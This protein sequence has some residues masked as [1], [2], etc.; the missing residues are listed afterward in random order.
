MKQEFI[1]TSGENYRNIGILPS[2]TCVSEMMAD[3]IRHRME[4]AGLRKVRTS[5]RQGYIKRSSGKCV[6]AHYDGRLGTGYSVFTPATDSSR[7]VWVT[8]YVR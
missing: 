4:R 5:R 3:K 6:V 7:Y 1:W 2:E 8:Y